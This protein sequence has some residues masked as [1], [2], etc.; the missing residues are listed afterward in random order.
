MTIVYILLFIL[1]LSTLIMVHEAG[2][3]ATAKIFK[4]YCFEYAIGFGP[5]IFS[6]KRKGGETVFSLRAIPF[7]GFVSMYGENDTLPEGHEPIDESRSLNNIK[8]WKKCIILVAGVTMN[9]ILAITVFFIYEI[10]FPANIA[11]VGH[12]TIKKNS[13][14]YE[15][16]LRSKDYVYT[17][18]GEYKGNTYIYYDDNATLSYLD[19]STSNVYFGFN[20]SN[21]TLKNQNLYSYAIAFHRVDFGNITSGEYTPITY[22]DA[23]NGNYEDTEVVLN[24]IGG[25]IK[26]RAYKKVKLEDESTAYLMRIAIV[27]NYLDE[28]ESKILYSDIILTK[29]ELSEFSLVPNSAYISLVG[30]MSAKTTKKG[31]KFN[32]LNVSGTDNFETSYPDVSGG[33]LLTSKAAGVKPNRL[34]FNFYK[35]NEETNI[36]RGDAV[37]LENLELSDNGRLPKN[38]GV[39][40]QLDKHYQDYATAVKYSFKDF[41][42]GATL[43]VRGLGQL[44]TKDGFKNIGGIIAIGVTTTQ[45]LQENGFGLFI[46]YWALISVNLGIVNLLPFPGLDGWQL[47]VT[48]VEGATRKTIP[49]KAK[50]IVSAV[51][52]GLLFILMILIII[53][54]LFMVI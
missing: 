30:D 47:L 14:A 13:I 15:A 2:H 6:F 41:G 37:P 45:V 28:D 29:D 19:S 31:E 36:G 53:K 50:N 51:G 23:I 42:N 44:F 54:D 48:I 46:F 25:Y 24:Q 17:P 4:V 7:G 35:L 3:L 8:K 27:E 5:K 18:I 38:I 34:S 22:E 52:I 10:A 33:N 49:P 9:F 20:Y 39:A 32:V 21:I 1:C 11:R 40:M 26:G 12:V 43:I 16:G